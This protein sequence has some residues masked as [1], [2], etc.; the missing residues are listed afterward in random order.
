MVASAIFV[1]DNDPKSC[2]SLSDLISGFG[3][4]VDVACN[5]CAAL[6]R[7]WRQPSGL[8]FPDHNAQGMDGGELYCPQVDTGRPRG[9]PGDGLRRRP[10]GRRAARLM[11]STRDRGES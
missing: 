7:S 11:G 1:V 3:Y 10:R 9:P 4:R 8:P 2:A 6:E 5:G